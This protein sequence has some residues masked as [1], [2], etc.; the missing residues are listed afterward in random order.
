MVRRM[1]TKA[2]RMALVQ[3]ALT[4]NEVGRLLGANERTARR[5]ALGETDVPG[6][7]ATMIRLWLERPELVGVVRSFQWEKDAARQGSYGQ[8][9]RR[10]R[11]LPR[12]AKSLEPSTQ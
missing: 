5:W 12:V 4:Q 7:V 2:Y 3:L 9:V 1:S 6:P 8:D 10:P 11:S